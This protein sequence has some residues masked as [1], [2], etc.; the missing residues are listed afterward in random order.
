M[1]EYL[2]YFDIFDKTKDKELIISDKFSCIMSD[3]MSVITA[4]LLVAQIILILSPD[5]HRDLATV[6]SLRSGDELVNISLSVVVDM[7]CYYLH[8]DYID[9]LGFSQSYINNTIRFRRYSH[10]FT[11][12]G[13]SN[14]SMNDVCY[15]CFEI[16]NNETCCNSCNQLKKMYEELN[17][18]ATPELWPQCNASLPKID[19]SEK[20]L[21]KGKV[22]ANRVKG[23]FHIAPGRNVEIDNVQIHELTDDFPS[24]HLSHA[25]ERIRFGPKIITANQPLQNL[26]MRA[27]KKEQIGYHYSLLVTPVILVADNQFIEKSF[28]YTV[29]VDPMRNSTP[30]IYFDYQFTPYTIQITWISRSFRGFLIS[31]CGFAA[32]LYAIGSIIDQIYHSYFPP[33]IE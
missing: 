10:N 23:S 9:T 21:V 15:P 25:I 6:H 7:P 5:I 28:E 18:T 1:A 24:L 32:G 17:L 14:S 13:I 3:A 16:F 4:F 8:F 11:Y 19:Q 27:D 20:C 12:I 22:A 26:V 29:V 33:K 31:F 30:G 2:L